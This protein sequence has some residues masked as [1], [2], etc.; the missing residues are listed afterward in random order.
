ME[1]KD[2]RELEERLSS[3]VQM[4]L[5]AGDQSYI[6][7]LTREALVTALEQEIQFLGL[8]GYEDTA[9][10]AVVHAYLLQNLEAFIRQIPTETRVQIGESPFI[11]TTSGAASGIQRTEG[12][13]YIGFIPPVVYQLHATS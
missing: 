4:L 11:H 9:A 12:P 7:G 6:K 13:R 3:I 1:P 5:E 8:Y 2:K 10:Q